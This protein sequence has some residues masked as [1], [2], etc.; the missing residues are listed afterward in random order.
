MAYSEESVGMDVSF[1]WFM[2]NNIS[3]LACSVYD[4]SAN[5][6]KNLSISFVL[7]IV[8]KVM[9]KQQFYWFE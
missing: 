8:I 3:S 2:L 5:P 6:P 7:G 4:A 9:I 1:L